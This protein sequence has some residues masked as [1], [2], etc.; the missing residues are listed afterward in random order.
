MEWKKVGPGHSFKDGDRVVDL[1]FPHYGP[2]TLE[3]HPYPASVRNQ[4][5]KWLI[6]FDDETRPVFWISKGGEWSQLGVITGPD[7]FQIHRR[8]NHEPATL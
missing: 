4:R 5:D 1:M 6:R 3:Q 7:P 2:A 8:L